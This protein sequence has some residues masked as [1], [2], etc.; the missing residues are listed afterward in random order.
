MIHNIEFRVENRYQRKEII[1]TSLWSNSSQGAIDVKL[2]N[3]SNSNTSEKIIVDSLSDNK[4]ILAGSADTKEELMLWANGEIARERLAAFQVR[5]AIEGSVGVK[6]KIGDVALFEKFA[7]LLDRESMITGIRHQYGIGQPWKTHLQCGFSYLSSIHNHLTTPS[8]AALLPPVQG[9]HIGIVDTYPENKDKEFLIPIKL[10]EIDAKKQIWARM[11][12]P[13]AGL[14]RGFFFVPEPEDEVIV[15]FVNEDP[16]YPVI[17]GT[18]FHKK[19]KDLFDV[20]DQQKG[21]ITRQGIEFMFDNEEDK[22]EITVPN[23]DKLI[24]H[25][26]GIDFET[27]KDIIFDA[28]ENV[29]IQA[30][31]S[32]IFK[33]PKEKIA[34]K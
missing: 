10:P 24:I 16:R 12:A 22:I 15:A 30:N 9:L 2:L 4:K 28:K 11:C 17:L 13:D 26:K 8:T 14:K 27:E 5:V 7:T 34:V 33:S 32:I 3:A 31:K 23:K 25:K 29:I 21:V 1:A 18:V 20:M 19:H 6:V